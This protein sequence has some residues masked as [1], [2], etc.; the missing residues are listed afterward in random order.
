MDA[1]LFLRLEKTSCMKR[2]LRSYIKL[3]QLP[4]I[5]KCI[6]LTIMFVNSV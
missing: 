4:L 1:F 5:E 3:K 2:K 6:C